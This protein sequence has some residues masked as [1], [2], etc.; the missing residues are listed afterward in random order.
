[1][2]DRCAGCT[3]KYGLFERPSVCPEC[4]RNFCQT[5]LPYQGKK[6]KKSEPQVALAPCVYCQRKEVIKE[7]QEKEILSNFQ[8]RYYNRA[9]MDPPIQSTLRLDLVARQNSSP[10]QL[11]KGPAVLPEDRALEER[12]KKLR[13]SY[14]KSA[15]TSFN[16]EEMHTRLEALRGEVDRNKRGSDGD[17]G[18][19]RDPET[20]PSET[21][22]PDTSHLDPQHTGTTQ[23]EQADRLME[24]ATDEARIDDRL[25]RDNEGRD[26]ELMKRFQNLKGKKDA[27]RGSQDSKTAK[28][29]SKL[30]FDVDELLGGIDDPILPE[31]DAEKL[32]Q[33]LKSLQAKEEMA[34]EKDVQSEDIQQFI[35]MAQKLAKEEGADVKEEGAPD[36]PLPNIVYP[37]LEAAGSETIAPSSKGAVSSADVA[38]MLEEGREELKMDQEQHEA[39]LKFAKEASERMNRLRSDAHRTTPSDLPDDEVVKSKPK[40]VVT[41]AP[42]LDFSWGHFGGHSE[43]SRTGTADVSGRDFP[44]GVGGASYG[45]DFPGGNREQFDD[46]VQDLIAR[47]LEEAELDR[48]LEASGLNDQTED[49]TA[50]IPATEPRTQTNKPSPAVATAQSPVRT[51]AG[52]MGGACGTGARGDLDD[53]P[54]C[55]ICNDDASICC[56]DCDSD[57]Y[58]QRCFAEGHQQFGLVDHKHAPFQPSTK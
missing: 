12:L 28:T 15:T 48:R 4:H 2:A 49:G 50:N 13:K 8:E 58:C 29:S 39:N 24:Q 55:C 42:C 6:V 40:S 31:E 23:T 16:E 37:D 52:G 21:R 46:E 38:K 7:S 33:D 54:W 45:N 14:H 11:R 57:L 18:R 53:L 47:M 5:C 36:D 17:G 1:M 56:Y 41:V 32:L 35:N 22:P 25:S 9:Y 44:V 43:H 3:N 26:E 20:K 30:N 34:A 27:G 51:A 19:E 10:A